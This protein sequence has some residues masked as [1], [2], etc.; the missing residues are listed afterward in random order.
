[1]IDKTR[2]TTGSVV[3]MMEA[4]RGLL[5]RGH[6]V[7][8][9]SRSGGDLEG[10]CSDAG[11]PFFPLPLRGPADLV[12]ALRLRRR[13]RSEKPMIVHAH[14]GSSHAI[15]LLAAAGFGS[16][17]VLVVNRGVSFP[18]D[19]FNRWKYRHSRVGA[20]VCVAE[21]IRSVV[22]RSTGLDPLQA[23]VIHAG[24][25]TRRFN[26]S[27]IDGAGVRNDLGLGPEDL[28]VGQI[29]VRDWKGWRNL[30]MAF[31]EVVK[32][33][34]NARLLL[35]GC[36]TTAELDKVKTTAR[37]LGCIDRVLTLP[38]RADMP[39]VLAACDVV[40]DASWAGTGI[41]G[42]LREGMAMERAVIGTDCGGNRELVID[43]E[44]GLLVPPRD[45][46]A[47][48]AAIGRLLDNPSL[49][50]R[51]G[52]AARRRVVTH[53]STEHR[54]DRLETLYRDLV[55]RTAE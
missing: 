29:S 16:S 46:S 4:A 48:A 14:K 23:V 15:A 27:A 47:L 34:P 26:P 51:L 54:L 9:T 32:G 55:A 31:A 11:I 36:E 12:S 25:D 42:T 53:F 20:V 30:L 52:K 43:R 35:V 28:L 49:R 13:L 5:Q 8:V 33:R 19:R 21:N 10:A 50:T 38:F 22:I 24:T 3:Q 41:T 2:L 39:E 7:W 44:V 18:L 17:P 1:M 40:V 6:R 37:D 45:V